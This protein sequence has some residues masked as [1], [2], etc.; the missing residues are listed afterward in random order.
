MERNFPHLYKNVCSNTP[1]KGCKLRKTAYFNL[2]DVS[3]ISLFVLYSCFPFVFY[4]FLFTQ[5]KFKSCLRNDLYRLWIN[6]FVGLVKYF[7]WFYINVVRRTGWN[8]LFE[9]S[10][11]CLNICRR[12]KYV[13]YRMKWPLFLFATEK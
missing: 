8:S 1:D 5:N 3:V 12:K 11:V 13:I 6:V 7:F 9:Q 2:V 4:V 10:W